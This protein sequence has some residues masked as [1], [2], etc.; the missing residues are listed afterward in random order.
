VFPGDL[1]YVMVRARKDPAAIRAAL[2]RG[3]FYAS[4]GVKLGSIESTG[5]RLSIAIDP[6]SA[7]AHRFE[8]IGPG[9]R[10]L[11]RQQGQ[12][13]SFPIAAAPGSYVRAVVVDDQRRRAWL[14]PIR[15]VT[16]AA[17]K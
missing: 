15:D 7:G 16:A 12:Q 4:T 1:G 9:G 5:A 11:A 10:V 2:E 17:P 8:L 13:A 14:Q 6:A 3:D